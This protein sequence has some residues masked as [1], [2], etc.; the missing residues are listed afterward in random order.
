VGAIDRRA[1]RRAFESRF[2]ARRMAEEYVAIYSRAIATK[3]A[4]AAA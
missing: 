4:T 1:C 3:S 2:T